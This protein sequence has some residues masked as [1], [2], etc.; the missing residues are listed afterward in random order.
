MNS[1]LGIILAKYQDKT[2][3]GGGS[4]LL[5]QNTLQYVQAK[6][7]SAEYI[8]LYAA[9]YKNYVYNTLMESTNISNI[10]M[11][12]VI[13][14]LTRNNTG[15]PIYFYEKKNSIGAHDAGGFLDI[16]HPI[17]R[18]KTYEKLN[19]SYIPPKLS[20]NNCFFYKTPVNT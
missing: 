12:D 20:S 6:Q 18:I 2:N 7:Y 19:A 16:H 17:F 4:D 11:F 5:N 10:F 14:Q 3:S 9:I 13:P 8:I 15:I 1:D